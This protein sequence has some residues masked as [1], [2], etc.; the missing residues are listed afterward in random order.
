MEKQ[1]RWYDYIPEEGAGLVDT[2][3]AMYAGGWRS[4]DHEQALEELVSGQYASEDDRWT[5]DE[6]GMIFDILERYE[7]H[8]EEEESIS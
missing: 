3:L 1:K 2:A 8:I 7:A 4:T 5:E 6:L